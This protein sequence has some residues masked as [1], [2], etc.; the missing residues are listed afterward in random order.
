M[1]EVYLSDRRDL[2][3]IVKGNR[4]PPVAVSARWQK[5][6]KKALRVSDEIRFTVQR[7]GYHLR[8]VSDQERNQ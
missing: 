5:R 3:V 4:V 2:L 7:Q 8:K 6:K 1:F